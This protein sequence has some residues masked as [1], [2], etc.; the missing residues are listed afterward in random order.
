MIARSLFILLASSSLSF[1]ALSAVYVFG[2]S[3]S[4]VGNARF[5][6]EA[7]PIIPEQ[8]ARYSN[9]PVWNERL[10]VPMIPSLEGGTNYAVGGAQTD[11]GLIPLTGLPNQLSQ[12]ELNLAGAAAD[13]DALYVLFFGGNDIARISTEAPASALPSILG[14]VNN[15]VQAVNTLQ[16]LG[17]ERILVANAP[18]VSLTPLI[19]NN[20]A[21]NAAAL[22]A[23]SSLTDIWNTGLATALSN[24]NDPNVQL[25]DINTP[26]LDR[27][28][29]PSGYGLTNLTD[30][31]E[32][33]PGADP[34]EYFFWDEF[35][36][37]ESAHQAI[38][39]EVLALTAV[40]EPSS[41][42]LIASSGLFLLVRRR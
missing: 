27:F 5:I 6:S 15:L 42:L 14:G 18:D 31:A 32:S 11:R 3:L 12:F 40:P 1:G 16:G 20:F 29:N 24:L 37:T 38:A 9:G 28:N 19:I 4:D 33:V 21:G 2:D 26:F 34:D 25:L 13:P 10:G 30:P 22:N 35:H 39:D 23:V 7:V 8:P 17:A 36:P 41:V